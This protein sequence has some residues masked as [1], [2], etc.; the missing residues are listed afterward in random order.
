MGVVAGIRQLTDEFYDHLKTTYQQ[1]R[2][3]LCS[4]LDAAGLTPILP[5][6]SY[7]VLADISR[8]PGKKSK[9]KVM[10]LLR[11]TK[12]AAVPGEAFYHGSAGESIA[13]FCFAKRDT[14]LREAS[15]ILGSVKF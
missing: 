11:K 13:R 1:K 6:G 5:R 4:A 10:Y 15:H 12:I 14:V 3:I 2:E 9:E 8:L 7:Y